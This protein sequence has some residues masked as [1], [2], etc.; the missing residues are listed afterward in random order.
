MSFSENIVQTSHVNVYYPG[1]DH[2]SGN[3]TCNSNT[4]IK[5]C[6]GCDW[7]FS[8]VTCNQGCPSQPACSTI[9]P[10]VCPSLGQNT[11]FQW[12]TSNGTCPS[13]PIVKCT[14][15]ASTFN[16]SDIQR[17]QA[18]F[19]DDS[20]CSDNS[21]FNN[22]IMPEFCFESTTICPIVPGTQSS[23]QSCPN[24]LSNINGDSSGN[25]GAVCSTWAINNKSISDAA[26]IDHCSNNPNDGTCQCVNRNNSAVFNYINNGMKQSGISPACWYKS[27]ANPQAFLVPSNLT[28]VTC[29]S[30]QVCNR[31]NQI[32]ANTPTNLTI[33]QLQAELSC[34]IT[35]TPSQTN[36]SSDPSSSTTLVNN[37]PI[38]VVTTSNRWIWV[39]II[40]IIIILILIILFF[41]FWPVSPRESEV[42]R[43]MGTV[44]SVSTTD[45]VSTIEMVPTV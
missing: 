4:P 42:I 13:L 1:S 34:N 41:I 24:I 8:T 29:D 16:F 17:Y 44:G 25:A 32:I 35:A 26:M 27:C 18:S 31:V 21:N 30:A 20:D 10:N 19:C 37:T 40:I 39:A 2:C 14:Y 23:W 28:N 12:N 45:S 33:Q 9:D 22:I 36:T 43:P 6:N 3:T 15:D 5:A 11:Q 38:G 7:E